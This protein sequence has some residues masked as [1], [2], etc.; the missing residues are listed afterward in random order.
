MPASKSSI[1]GEYTTSKLCVEEGQSQIDRNVTIGTLPDDVLLEI[2]CFYVGQSQDIEGWIPL[3]HVCQ[4]WRN[5]VFASPRRLNLR[6]LCDDG[7]PVEEMLHIWPAL[8]IVIS[9]SEISIWYP[10]VA[11]RNLIAAFE[12]NDRVC[13]IVLSNIENSAWETISYYMDGPFPVLERLDISSLEWDW[14]WG[15]E[16]AFYDWRLGGSAPNLK[17]LSFGG[18]PSPPIPPLLLSASGLVHLYLSGVPGS[19]CEMVTCLS[20]LTNLQTFRL[21]FPNL[22]EPTSQHLPPATRT[23][24]P[25]L[26]QFQFECHSKYLEDLLAHITAPLLRRLKIV[27]DGNVPILGISQVSQFISRTEQFKAFNQ[28][29]IIFRDDTTIVSLISGE[30]ELEMKAAP[31]ERREWRLLSFA[32]I[33]SSTLPLLSTLERIDITEGQRRLPIWLS[34]SENSQWL[35]FLRRFTTVKNLYLSRQLTLRFAT[36]LEDLVD[37]SRTDVLPALQNLFLEGRRPLRHIRVAIDR[38]VTARRHSGCPVAVHY[39][40]REEGKW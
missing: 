34:N 11:E 7:K 37:E 33:Y 20:K 40:Q 3:V 29:N 1:A 10:T 5:I 31:I 21:D 23:V 6:L 2:F 35:D 13:E 26:S 14:H 8:P 25:A 4:R 12:H 38:F 16:E 32:Q 22:H 30:V 27:F 18:I 19:P 28:A 17:S 24:L 15:Q 9:D 36:G 39:C